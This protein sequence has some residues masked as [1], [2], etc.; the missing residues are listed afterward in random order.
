[1][2]YE[3]KNST[4]FGNIFRGGVLI[5]LIFSSVFGVIFS[6][7]NKQSKLKNAPIKS[8]YYYASATEDTGASHASSLYKGGAIYL[9][10]NSSYT[11][12]GGVKSGNSKTYGG[13]VYVSSGATFTMNAGTIEGNSATYGG[14]VYIEAGGTFIMN[15]GKIINNS[16]KTAPAVYIEDGG[17]FT[18][19]AGCEISDNYFLKVDYQISEDTVK[20]GHKTDGVDMHYIEYGTYPQTYVG[21][22]MNETMESW[23]AS[24]QPTAVK[25]Y[26]LS[27]GSEYVAWKSY[28]YSDNQLYV[29]GSIGL[30]D[31]GYVFSTGD[32]M[33]ITGTICWFK[34][35]PIKWV[36]LNYD[37]VMS[38][39]AKTIEV[40]SLCGLVA[41]IKYHFNVENNKWHDSN[42]RTWLNTT[43]YQTAF[44]NNE[45]LNIKLSTVLNCIDGDIFGAD[46]DGKGVTTYDY[47]YCLSCYELFEVYFVDINHR[48]CLRTDFAMANYARIENDDICFYFTR[49]SGGNNTN[50]VVTQHG[51][52]L[53]NNSTYS[54]VAVR[55]V[56]SLII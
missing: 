42:L 5:A 8:N 9:G 15:G 7:L 3:K 53:L 26:N 20:V 18:V 11:M 12:N 33:G 16:A 54:D 44:S 32:A 56:M 14:A 22:T 41:N 4:N 48:L 55:P 37:E 2:Y 34:V 45:R 49:S 47:L 36:V 38:N 30:R 40:L 50:V 1:M 6:L 10:I 51:N 29:R 24:E 27:I 43:F 52:I 19:K 13:A 46:S 39:S 35:E 25:D 31:S 28:L 23:F 17:T 21:N